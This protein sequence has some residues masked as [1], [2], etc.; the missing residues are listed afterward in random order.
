MA[1]ALHLAEKSLAIGMGEGGASR[2]HFEE[3]EGCGGQDFRSI[4]P[5]ETADFLLVA[6]V[7]C[8][9]I[10]VA[11]MHDDAVLQPPLTHPRPLSFAHPASLVEGRRQDH[12]QPGR[13]VCQ[14]E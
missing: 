8:F 3:G 9:S 14:Y 10:P 1:S 12:G 11:L 5:I 4:F 7:G 6:R 13:H 2:R